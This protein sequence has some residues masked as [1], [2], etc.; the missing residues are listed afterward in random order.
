MRIKTQS[1]QYLDGEATQPSPTKA[2]QISTSLGSNVF[3]VSFFILFSSSFMC[4]L[5]WAKKKKKVS[6]YICTRLVCLKYKLGPIDLL[7]WIEFSKSNQNF[8]INLYFWIDLHLRG[9]CEYS[10]CFGLNR[11]LMKKVNEL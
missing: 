7:F 2:R 1:G 6:I 3:L 10:H 4:C 9:H 8:H 5:G 11:D